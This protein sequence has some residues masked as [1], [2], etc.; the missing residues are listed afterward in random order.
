MAKLTILLVDD[1][2]DSRRL[3]R[4]AL[5]GAFPLINLQEIASLSSLDRALRRSAPDL[6]VTE[7][8]LAGAD[9]LAVVQRIKEAAPD[10][11]V[12]IYTASGGEPVAGLMA[13]VDDYVMKSRTDPSRLVDAVRRVADRSTPGFDPSQGDLSF[14]AMFDNLPVGV[15]RTSPEG[16]I[17]EA[18]RALA[19]MLGCTSVDELLASDLGEFYADP[20]DRQ[21]WREVLELN[22]SVKDFEIRMRRRDGSVLWVRDSGR[23]VRGP[24]G[25]VVC[26]E[27]TLTDASERRLAEERLSRSETELK[28]AQRVARV[29]SWAWHI[30]SNRLEWSDEMFRIFGI[31]RQGFSGDLGE[32][33]AGTIHP[34]DRA[35]VERSNRSV[36]E[37]R[38]PMPLEYRIVRPDGTV[39][40]VWAEAGE[41]RLD[42]LGN[43]ETLTGIVQDISERKEAEDRLRRG[44]DQVQA[45][46]QSS[47]MAIVVIGT[48]RRVKL[49]NPAAERMFGWTEQEVIG[50]PV[51]FVP[52]EKHEDFDRNV[53]RV[54]GG[55]SL[56]GIDV[57]RQRKDGSPVTVRL[58]TAPLWD[59]QGRVTSVFAMLEDVSDQRR[60]EEALGRRDAV[61][62]AVGDSATVLL[63]A[64]A[65]EVQMPDVLSRLG[66]AMGVSRAY[67]FQRHT[68]PIGDEV[69]SQRHEWCAPGI[70]PQI[71]NPEL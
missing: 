45:V 64:G 20:L 3:T 46:L 1:N 10:C 53:R 6:V 7:D 19:A 30:P 26:Y 44:L 12:V 43:P 27:G 56:T 17:L 25:K 58:S 49:W 9:G 2:K 57:V 8:R 4:R 41:L 38:K 54:L 29:G 11:A 28:N 36:I 69:V 63:E 66:Q 14:Q 68:G 48:D 51:P 18:N 47:P 42:A 50:G 34:E 16:R 40:T 15:Y 65:W 67:L 70:T 5:E 21:R 37:E 62:A 60:I 55:E 59:D 13:M 31:E 61:L 52:V 39:R 23:T 24:G 22:Q 32:V 71:Q 35:A 33:V